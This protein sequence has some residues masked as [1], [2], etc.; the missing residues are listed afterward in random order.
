MSA[1]SNS[2]FSVS[3]WRVAAAFSLAMRL[4]VWLVRDVLVQLDSGAFHFSGSKEPQKNRWNEGVGVRSR[5]K[6]VST[7]T[8]AGLSA[9]RSECARPAA[10]LLTPNGLLLQSREPHPL[11]SLL[12]L[13]LSFS[14]A[15]AC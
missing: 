14:S 8:H 7:V 5:G 6:S 10:L 12:M 9:A 15:R 1:G 11:Q 4:G 2:P 13:L 3:D